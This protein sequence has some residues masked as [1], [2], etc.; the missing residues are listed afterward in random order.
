RK[1]GIIF[2]VGHGAGSF[3]WRQAVPAVKQGVTPD[4]ISTD[5]HIDSMNAGMKDMLNLLSKFLT[6]GMTVDDVI[7]RATWN[8]ARE[9]H[10]E[11][12]GHLTP[13][14]VADVAV[15]RLIN[16][17]FGFIDSA[18]LRMR[19]TQKLVAELTIR[20]GKVVW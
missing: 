16:G 2:D 13:G 6:M 17:D 14:A 20:E 1:R 4:S 10:H 15:L 9:I 5:L 7:V 12:L 3:Y 8:P 19:G 18:N 11:E